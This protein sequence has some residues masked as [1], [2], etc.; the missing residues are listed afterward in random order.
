MTG[1]KGLEPITL[2]LEDNILPLNYPLNF[3]K[4]YKNLELDIQIRRKSV[5]YIT[6]FWWKTV[7]KYSQRYTNKD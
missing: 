7:K 6:A 2:T 5:A 1:G 4:L 3:K